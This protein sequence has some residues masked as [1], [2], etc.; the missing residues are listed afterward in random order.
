MEILQLLLFM[1]RFN[2]DHDEWNRLATGDHAKSKVLETDENFRASRAMLDMGLGIQWM[3]MVC[4]CKYGLEISLGWEQH[5]F[6]HQ[7]QLWRVVR[8][9]DEGNGIGTIPNVPNKHG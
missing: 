2:V 5:I 8:I 7:N 6:Y 4:D 9:G 1:G 3:G